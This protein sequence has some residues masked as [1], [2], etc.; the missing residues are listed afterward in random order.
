MDYALD[1]GTTNTVIA[2]RNQA[3]IV[4]TVAVIPNLVY[5]ENAFTGTVIIGQEIN[6][7]PQRLFRNFKRAIATEIEGFVPELDGVE[8]TAK[9]VGIWFLQGIL[10]QLKD[11]ARLVLTVPVE[12]FEQYRQWLLHNVASLN[13]SEIRI[14]DESTSA[15]LGYGITAGQQTVLVIDFGGGT[16]DVSVVRLSLDSL[17]SK[18]AINFLL[19]WADRRSMS[20]EKSQPT[21]KVL[22]KTGQNLGGMD[23]DYW[24]MDY[25]ISQQHLPHSLI[26]RAIAEKLKI[27]LSTAETA[28]LT[29]KDCLISL[30]RSQLEAILTSH[31][32]FPRFNKSLANIQAQLQRRDLSFASLDAVILVG[33]SAQMPAL[34]DWVKQSFPDLP[35]HADKPLEAIAHGAISQDWVLAD[36]LYHSYGVRYWDRRNQCH[37]W[38]TIFPEGQT[39]PTTQPYELVL[40]ASLPNQPCIELVIGEIAS[41]DTEVVYEEGQLV[42]KELLARVVKAYPLNDSDTGRVIAPLDPVG[43][44]GTDRIKVL[45]EIDAQRTLVM[46]VIDLLTQKKLMQK[47]PV[48]K[49]Q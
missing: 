40:G 25:L 31:N 5:V 19:K 17:Q 18:S 11:I 21:A 8:V 45:L 3:G 28:S 36:Y 49:L 38:H 30:D 39:Y 4:E 48:I 7:Q 1:F 12:S 37:N 13:A 14:I 16:L 42:V 47:Q 44:V 29:C 6:D 35:I 34:Q 2:R 46:T 20:A 32:F 15:A 33:G 10:G 9:Q 27:A 23:I 43:E 26:D 41:T 22:A 24:I